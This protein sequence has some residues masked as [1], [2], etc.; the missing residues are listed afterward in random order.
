MLEISSNC[1][2]DQVHSVETNVNIQ[3]MQRLDSHFFM[4]LMIKV[5]ETQVEQSC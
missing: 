5:R 3:I 4:M 2:Y 1:A